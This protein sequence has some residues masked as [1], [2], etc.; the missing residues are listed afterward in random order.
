[1]KAKSLSLLFD[2]MHHGKYDFGD[3]LGCDVSACYKGGTVKGRAILQ[4]NKKLKAYHAFL[5][6][7]LVDFLEL[8]QRVVFA[9]RKGVNPHDAVTR[10]AKN[11]AFFQ[12]DIENFFGSVTREIV[13]STIVQ[14][15]ENIPVLDLAEHM[16]RILDLITVDGALPAGFSTSPSISNACLRD[17]D[18]VFERYCNDHQLTYTRYADDLIVSGDSREALKDIPSVIG[19][20]LLKH[21]F[22]SFKLNRGKS[23]LTTIGRKIKVLG[24]VI[25]PSGRATVDMELKKRIE[26]LLHFY[27]RDREKFLN[28]VNQD[29]EAG[30]TQLSGYVNYINAADKPYLEKLK[31]KFGSTVVDSFLHRSAT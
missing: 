15:A 5:C 22:E 13:Q 24:M 29:L 30:I 18:N 16:E 17:F 26:V 19:K 20:L 12:T 14:N 31:K 10:H 25:L 2:A 21:S 28:V 23:K 27:I 11:R 9:Y 8:N 4:P 1:M 6:S 3:F 7:F